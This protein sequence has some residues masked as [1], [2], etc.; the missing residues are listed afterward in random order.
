MR[1]LI[2]VLLLFVTNFIFGQN[3]VQWN[4]SVERI[5]DSTYTLIVEAE[6]KLNWHLYAVSQPQDE[7]P[8]IIP[9][10]FNFQGEGVDFERMGAIEEGKPITEMDKIFEQE[11]SYFA[12]KAIFKQKIK[13][14]NPGL[15]TVIGDVSYQACDDKQCIFDQYDLGFSLDGSAVIIDKVVD[16]KSLDLAQN[17]EIPLTNTDLLKANKHSEDA[18][19]K[20]LF[21]LFVLGF[22]GGL[23]ALLTPC[24]FPMIPLTVSFFT[25]QSSN[26]S[27]GVSN[28]ILYGAFIV[29]I[30]M[31]LSVPFHFLDS[32]APEILNN[33]STNVWLNV[34][35]FIIFVVFA[36]SFFGYF[37]LT[38]PHSWGNKMDSASGAGGVIGIF[39][40]ALTLAIVSFSCT[41]PILGSLL[42]GSLSN[43]G[44]ATQLTVGMTGF[45]VAL[46]LPFALFALFPNMLKSLPRSGGWMT[47]TKVILGFLELAMAFKF[48]SNADLVEHWGI[49]KREV[50]IGIWIVIFILMALYVFGLI[51]FPHDGPRK[52]LSFY[53]FIFGFAVIGFV[54]YLIPGLFNTSQSNLK[55]LSGFPPPV[56]YSIYEKESDC[57]L[58]LT[59]FKDFDEGLAYAKEHNKPILLDFT[60][61]ACVNCR[62]MEENVWSEPEIFNLLNEEYVLISLYVDDRKELEEGDQFNFELENGRVKSIKTIGD[63]WATFQTINFK[64]ASQPYYIQMSSDYELL[65]SPQKYTDAI[66]YYQWLQDGLKKFAES[67][68]K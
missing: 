47:T 26:K 7:E 30:Y 9:T 60:G 48:L 64:T 55:L 27:K 44:G 49:L 54:I 23:I 13:L 57:P 34:T 52:K 37:E 8:A 68:D 35:F 5:S 65:S 39:F 29:G 22:L 50:F 2:A 63:K 4:T 62:K 59:C 38:L 14:L 12:D 1:N 45:G 6:I 21:N 20:G 31:A 58:G 40:M 10:T 41:G 32:I 17:L 36:F 16:A 53:R 11:L 42:A 3:Q 51:R 61:W 15:K 19:G 46:A 56:F 18:Q 43:D 24:V 33:I 28:A 66:T 25:K 67:Q